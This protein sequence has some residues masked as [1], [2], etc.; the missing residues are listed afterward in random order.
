[1]CIAF[2][3]G[4]Q[5]T[6]ILKNSFL[7]TSEFSFKDNAFASEF[8]FYHSDANHKISDDLKFYLPVMMDSKE[9]WK[10]RR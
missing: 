4:Y 10:F 8:M 7:A 3:G 5:S 2:I 1:M 9:I 6:F